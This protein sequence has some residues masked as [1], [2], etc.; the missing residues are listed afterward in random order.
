[1]HMRKNNARGKKQCICVPVY[2]PEGSGKAGSRLCECVMRVSV[3]ELEGRGE[4]GGFMYVSEIMVFLCASR[5]PREYPLPLS[6]PVI[7]TIETR[8]AVLFTLLSFNF[9]R[10]HIMLWTVRR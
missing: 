1:M 7:F 5:D 8:M 6:F 2:L 10:A 9:W 4:G 3:S